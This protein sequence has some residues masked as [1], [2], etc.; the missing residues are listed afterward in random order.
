M[1]KVGKFGLNLITA[2]ESLELEAYPD[3][4]SPLGQA[5]AKLHR[6]MSQYRAHPHWRDLSGAPWTIGY[7]HTRNV[8]QGDKCTE[9]QATTWLHEDLFDAEAAVNQV[10][11]PL[12][13]FQ[14]DA[15]VSFVFN[16][17]SGNFAKSTLLRK[18]NAGDYDG[19]ADEFPRWNKSGGRELN[20][21][22]ARRADEKDLFQT[23]T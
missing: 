7:G 11:V 2:Y 20:G 4:G 3:P 21:L 12:S 19:A 22:T 23:P 13:Q 9:A 8:K 15:L 1:K 16:V 10:A 17:G 14:F 5:V 18:L 6:P